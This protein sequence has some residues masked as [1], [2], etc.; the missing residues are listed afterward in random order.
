MERK[1][2]RI[3]YQLNFKSILFALLGALIIAF[4]TYIYADSDIPKGGIIGICLILENCTGASLVISNIIINALCYLFAWR[5]M[6]T[7]Y[8]LNA[9][10]ATLSFSVFYTIFEI[11]DLDFSFLDNYYLLAALIGAA[12]IE[13]GT[14]ISIRYGSAPDGEH[15][16]SVSLEAKGDINAA[17]FG[18][19]VDFTVIL[20]SLVYVDNIYMIIFALIIATVT[21]PIKEVITKYPHRSEIAAQDGGKL[22]IKKKR[23]VGV[24]ATGLAII[25]VISCAVWV[26]GSY[27]AADTEAI[28]QFETTGTKVVELSDGSV[29]YEPTGEIKAGFVFYPGANVDNKA[30]EPLLRACAERGIVCISVKMPANLAIFGANK[31]LKMLDLYPEVDSW[32]IGGHSLGG[33]MAASCVSLNGDTFDGIVLLASYSTLD[34]S[35]T[36]A[37]SVY[38]SRDGVLNMTSYNKYKTNLSGDLEEHIISGASHAYFGM[39]GKQRGDGEALISNSEQIRTTASYIAEFI[40]KK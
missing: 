25:T 8:I 21:I 30:Y 28:A 32:Y 34:I 6:G 5:L 19:I 3:F 23:L 33:S 16:L 36:P 1:V 35:S 2:K 38:G 29:A 37:L 40:V 13:I 15:A 12:L 18:F 24:I 4:G 11:I 31:A 9:G 17:W 20:A 26:N 7:R 27:Y 14:G 39:Y 22:R 10:M